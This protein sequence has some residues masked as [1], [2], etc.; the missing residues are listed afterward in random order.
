MEQDLIDD[1]MGI[2]PMA[3]LQTPQSLKLRFAA[4]LGRLLRLDVSIEEGVNKCSVFITL[5][6]EKNATKRSEESQV[7][8]R[9]FLETLE[10]TM[11]CIAKNLESQRSCGKLRDEL[12]I[13]TYEDSKST[14]EEISRIFEDNQ[15]L[16]DDMRAWK[17][18][19]IP[20]PKSPVLQQLHE[21]NKFPDKLWLADDAGHHAPTRQIT[22]FNW[23]L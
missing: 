6:N 5:T 9:S 12:L 17:P 11:S 4:R 10:N 8:I 15:G 19:D 18:A 1:A 13:F 23:Q 21:G 2:T 3:G 7:T 16:Y 20:L 14:I 22:R